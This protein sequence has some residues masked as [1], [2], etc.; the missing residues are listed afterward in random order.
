MAIVGFFGLHAT[1]NG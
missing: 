1:A